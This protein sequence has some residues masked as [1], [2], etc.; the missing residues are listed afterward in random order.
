MKTVLHHYFLLCFLLLGHIAFG[1]DVGLNIANSEI[2]QLAEEKNYSPT[3]ITGTIISDDYVS[4]GI[5]HIYYQQ[6]IDN[7]GI[8]GTSGAVH[9]KGDEIIA[10]NLNFLPQVEKRNIG[11]QFRVRALQALARLATDRG[12]PI[13]QTE[14]VVLEANESAPGKNTLVQANGISNRVIPL[15]LVYFTDPAA[16]QDIQL[17]WSVFIDEVAGSAYKNYMVS[18]AT[19]AVLFE[20]N[21]TINCTFDHDHSRHQHRAITGHANPA[22]STTLKNTYQTDSLYNVLPFSIESPNFGDRAIL[23]NPWENPI[24]SPNGWHRIASIDYQYTIGNNV[25]A[26]S[27]RDNTNDPTGAN[28]ARAFGGPD[29]VFDHPWDPN[30]TQT[31]YTK[32]AITNLFYMNNVAH[33][34]FYNYGFDEVSGN[35]QE[36]NFD[37]GGNGS[38]A[39]KAEAQDASGSCNANMSTPGDGANPRMQMYL[40]AGK[41]GDYDNGVILHEYGHGVSNRLTGGPQA[42]SCLGNVE[43]MGEGWSDFFGMILTMKAADIATTNRTI[44]TFMFNQ[45]ANGAGLRPYPYTTDM[46][47]NPMTYKTIDDEGITRPHGVGAVWATMLWDLNWALINQYGWD[48]DV[49]N[50]TGG[51]NLALRLVMEGLKIQPCSPGFVDA[52][53]AILAADLAL[54]NGVNRCIIWE[55][56]ARRGLGYSADQGSSNSRTDGAEGYDMPPEC[57]IE[58]KHTVDKAA[59]FLGE[60]LTFQ[61]T[62]IN[63]LNAIAPNIILTDTIPNNVQFYSASH[64]GVLNGN[65]VEWPALSLAVGDT[66][67]VELKVTIN[68]TIDFDA[69]FLD[70]SESGGEKWKVVQAS[71]NHTWNLQSEYFFSP[72]NSWF[73]TNAT[74]TTETHLVLKNPLSLTDSSEL[75]FNHYFDLEDRYDF[76]LVDISIDGGETWINLENNFTQNGYNNFT[77]FGH[78]AFSKTS[79]EILP[80][81]NGF[82]TSKAD[83]SS[84]AGEVAIIRFRLLTDINTAKFGWIVDDIGISNT[85]YALPN[86]SNIRN[87]EYDFDTQVETPVIISQSMINHTVE[88]V[89]DTLITV[90]NTA[91]KIADVQA[92]D[93]DADGLLDTLVTTILQTPTNGTTTVINNDSISYLPNTDFIGRDTVV[94]QVCDEANAC[95]SDTLFVFV[96]EANVAPVTMP[97]FLTINQ[98]TS[99]HF[100]RVQ[101][102]DSD[103][104]GIADT[105]VTSIL[106]NAANGITTVSQNDSINYTPTYGYF[107]LDTIIYQVCDIANLCTEDTIFITI[108]DINE[109]PTATTDFVTINKNTSNHFINVQSNDN[110]PDGVGD[111]LITS[112]LAMPANGTASVLNED[113]ISYTPVLNYFGLD[114]IIYQV[115]DTA[116]LC[117]TDTVFITINDV[118]EGPVANPDYTTILENSTDNFIH[119]QANDTDSNGVGDSLLTTISAMPL[120]GTAAVIN[121]DSISYSPAMN[122]FGLDTIVYQVCDTANLCDIDTIFITVIDINE[123]PI[124]AT[125]FLIINKNT[126]DN[127][128]NVQLNDSDPDGTGDTLITNIQKMPSNG[129]AS[130]INDD[131]ISY[132]PTLNY[133][134]LD[135][136]FYQVCDTANLC[137][138]DTVF[139]TINDVNESPVANP[140]YS[141][142]LENSTDNFINVQANDTDSN[143]AGD[144]LLTTISEMPSKGTATVLNEDSISYSPVMNYFGLDTIIYQICDTANL[145]ATDTIFLTIEEINKAPEATPDFD[146]VVINSSNNFIAVQANDTDS[147]GIGDSLLTTILEMPLHGTA[148]V[149]DN[150]SI[151]YSPTM[152]YIGLDTIVYQVCDTANLCDADTVFITAI[153]LNMAPTANPDYSTVLENS[154]NNFIAVQANDTDSNGAGDSLL[155]T[156]LEMPSN[157]TATVLNEDSISYSPVMNYF[158]LDTIVYQV[159]DTANL[160]DADTIFLTINY[161]NE[162]PI[163]VADFLDIDKN[164]SNNFINVQANDSDPDG[165]GDTLITTILEMPNHGTVTVVNDDSLSYTPTMAYFGLDTIVYQVCDTANLCASDTIFIAI[166]DYNEAPVTSPDNLQILENTIN[167]HIDVLGNDSDPN[168]I[169]DTLITILVK[170]AANGSSVVVNE[171]SIRYTPNASFVGLDTI[172]YS[173]CDTS[174]LCTIDTIFIEVEVEHLAP[175][176]QA[177]YI[178]INQNSQGVTIDVQAN[179]YDPNGIGD[180]LITSLLVGAKNGVAGIVQ[181]DSLIYTPLTDYFG[182][183]TIVY[184]VCDTANLC[185]SDTVFI[186]IQAVLFCE[187]DNLVK[188]DSDV[189]DGN[190]V[191]GNAITSAGII[192]SGAKVKFVAGS[193]IT[194][195]SGFHAKGGTDF[196]AMID[197]CEPTSDL[198]ESPTTTE[199]NTASTT[200]VLDSENSLQQ[201]NLLVRPNPFRGY[202]TIDYE[203]AEASPI[204]LGLHDLTGKVLH[205]FVNQSEQ[206]AGKHQYNLSNVELPSG[207]YWVSMR[208]ANTVITKKVLVLK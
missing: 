112:I 12:Y 121:E 49:Y 62:A 73:I 151:N 98:N 83:L 158:G 207:A 54:N 96:E 148:T 166:N 89:A 194:L 26:Y 88:T 124:S 102:N 130:V 132:T 32:A 182:L 5:R 127:F 138:T 53:D 87:N 19:G 178:T 184:Q 39:V 150:D 25:D 21:L 125:D 141:T 100:I 202:A 76:G 29:L 180:T 59:A 58:L 201:N 143:G 144:S 99:N 56:F 8:Y 204:W 61:L 145:C 2:E 189:I 170:A 91:A 119:V 70:D 134:G 196:T 157:G 66:S 205:V 10:S 163:A 63:H 27:D 114:T 179:D 181:E 110:D 51:N 169:R 103:P 190:Y 43:Q 64:G 185:T 135:T 123:A 136:I 173:A 197:E 65:V 82:I 16:G 177:D 44:G 137:A 7:I 20:N 174:N 156:I 46:G 147:N 15:K 23:A 67:S 149:V 186:T 187:A 36:E 86:F 55:V 11:S 117:A 152:G 75:S 129:T 80:N 72:S 116:N 22:P 176:T 81:N 92:N 1:Q 161:V 77:Q 18:A 14:V 13:S 84:Y 208:T 142:V 24:A 206:V 160:C 140:D 85:N 105:L 168:G 155:T 38:D 159:C 171:D 30:G 106:Q 47:V 41:D 203:L 78:N 50:G 79:A 93:I 95:E 122:Y 128:I 107:G 71:G 126:S 68:D 167:N 94:Y 33:D 40:C 9:L 60:R 192:N 52:R 131:S 69:D 74:T 101:A 57:T 195:L 42:V 3:D 4:G 162:A 183:D 31:D 199:R 111:T 113:S 198:T 154:S 188:N 104:N 48:A 133:F 45:E 146:T 34:I 165:I 120:H 28:N 17:A 191:A 175:I 164:T 97:D 139:I 172:V 118:N 90:E 109:A 35:F 108:L 37:K 115:C 153:D 200:D 193:T 6:T